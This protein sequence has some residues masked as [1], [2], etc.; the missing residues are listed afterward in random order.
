[1]HTYIVIS[2]SDIHLN[3]QR[4]VRISRDYLQPFTD[5]LSATYPRTRGQIPILSDYMKLLESRAAM[6]AIAMFANRLS[7]H[8]YM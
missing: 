7:A 5:L 4:F 3:E 6:L 1:M 8:T 2:S